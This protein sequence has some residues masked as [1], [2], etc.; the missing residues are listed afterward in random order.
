MRFDGTEMITLTTK[1][2]F[3]PHNTAKAQTKSAKFLRFLA[4]HGF[5]YICAF[6][7]GKTGK[8]HYHIIIKRIK[9]HLNIE[10]TGYREKWRSLSS[11]YYN[12]VVDA[13]KRTP[14]YVI[15]KNVARIPNPMTMPATYGWNRSNKNFRRIRRSMGAG[16]FDWE[17]KLRCD[18]ELGRAVL[19]GSTRPLRWNEP[20][21]SARNSA[22]DTAHDKHPT[23]ESKSITIRWNHLSSRRRESC[24]NKSC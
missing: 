13:G 21:Q 1:W 8:I 22:V 24:Q 18:K 16:D 11:C 2:N 23:G 10:D 4:Y 3:T 17:R 5:A 7:V 14:Y 19:S 9:G 12:Q 15:A 20:C 6:A